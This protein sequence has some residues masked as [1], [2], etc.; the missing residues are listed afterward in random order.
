[1]NSEGTAEGAADA[2]PPGLCARARPMLRRSSPRALSIASL[3]AAGLALSLAAIGRGGPAPSPR[4][5]TVVAKD[6]AP[7]TTATPAWST[8]ES[9]R[10]CHRKETGGKQPVTDF[11]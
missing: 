4:R 8:A 1:M 11:V 7:P 6:D 3:A 10:I 5:E 9:C 2:G